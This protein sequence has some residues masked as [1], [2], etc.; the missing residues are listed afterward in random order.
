MKIAEAGRA[1]RELNGW[2]DRTSLVLY[3]ETAPNAV[4]DV[5]RAFEQESRA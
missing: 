3:N 4:V 1:L 5:V 2:A